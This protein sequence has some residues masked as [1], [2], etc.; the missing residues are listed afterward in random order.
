MSPAAATKT[1]PK[2]E[3]F[4]Y[5]NLGPLLFGLL[6]SAGVGLVVC[7]LGAWFFGIEQFLFSWLFAFMFFFTL[8]AGSLFWILI[9]YAVDAEWSVVVRRLLETSAN[10]FSYIWIFFIPIALYARRIYEW[11]NVPVG[12]N[13][14]LDGK[15]GLLNTQFWYI[16]AAV[17]FVFF[18]LVTYLLR[19]WST[20]QDQTGDLGYTTKARKLTFA[21]IP[22]FG[23]FLTFAAINWVMSISYEWYSTMWGVYIFAGSAWSSMALLI[24]I[25]KALHNAGYLRT[26]ISTEHYHIMGK[27]LL[28]FTVFWAYIAFSQFFLIWYANIPDETAF[29]LRR[30]TESWNTMTI[31]LQVIGHFF[32]TFA[33]L[34]PRVTKTNPKYLAWISGWVLLMHLCDIYIIVMPFYHAKG[35]APNPLDL[36]ALV[37]IGAPLVFL[38]IQAL[39]RHSLYAVRDPR[40][41]ESLRLAN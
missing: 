18:A 28:S 39:G 6:V 34:L 33:L 30:N 40:L 15:R 19:R 36:A 14:V 11:M 9:H 27:L 17:F 5:T 29:F 41:A 24:L 35:F 32:V 25:T 7:I 13:P 38:F 3:F 10:S 22:F 31:G 20:R 2:E 23:V 1:P 37:T 21:A 16:S 12:E 8:T 4:Q 26:V